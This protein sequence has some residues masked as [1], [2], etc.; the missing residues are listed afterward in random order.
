LG[1][2]LE[3][4][5]EAQILSTPIWSDMTR[6]CFIVAMFVIVNS[7]TALHTKSMYVY[8][9]LMPNLTRLARIFNHSSPLN[10]TRYYFVFY[11]NIAQEN[12]PG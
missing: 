12:G 5:A 2:F 1:S 3:L 8:V 9:Y 11:K 4:I 7:Q 10:I 6:K